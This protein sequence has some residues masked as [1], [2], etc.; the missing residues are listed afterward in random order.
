[1]GIERTLI[2]DARVVGAEGVIETDVLLED[3]GFLYVSV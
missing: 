2:K 3:A 1:M